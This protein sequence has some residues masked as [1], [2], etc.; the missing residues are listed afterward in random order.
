MPAV[1]MTMPILPE[2]PSAAAAGVGLVLGAI[3]GSFL[4][5][6]VVR[7]PA[8]RAMSGRSACDGCGRPLGALA[9]VPLVSFLA[10]RGRCRACGARIDPRHF[11]IEVGAAAI[12]ATSLGLAP[13]MAGLAGALFGWLLLTLGV[14]DLQHFWVPDRLTGTLALIGLGAGAAGLPPTL[15]DR[16]AGGATGFAALALIGWSYR[17]L[18]GRVGLGQGDPKLLGAVGLWLGWAALPFVLLGASLFGLA[19][20]AVGRAAGRPFAGSDRLPLGTLMAAAA[21]PLWCIAQALPGF[22]PFAR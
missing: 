18:R 8:G 11:L 16:V 5:T 13:D 2:L 15:A 17:R 14:L 20:V 9:L 1:T 4:S 6:L 7:W 10:Q 22:L 19:V 12:G 3:A 21:W